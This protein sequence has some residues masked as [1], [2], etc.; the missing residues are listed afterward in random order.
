V[1]DLKNAQGKALFLAVHAG[2]HLLGSDRGVVRLR[3]KLRDGISRVRD[4]R[5]LEL[6]RRAPLPLPTYAGEFILPAIGPLARADLVALGDRV[7][8]DLVE[9]ASEPPE[10]RAKRVAGRLAEGLRCP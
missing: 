2:E 10:A 6:P 9:S 5:A 4:G 1:V 8:E 3:R 7:L